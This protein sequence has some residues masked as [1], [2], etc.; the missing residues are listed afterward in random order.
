MFVEAVHEEV[1]HELASAPSCPLRIS[2][3]LLLE[4]HMKPEINV[5]NRFTGGEQC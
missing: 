3:K 1:E 2:E 4:I 5:K